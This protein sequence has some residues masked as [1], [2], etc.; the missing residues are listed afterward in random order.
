MALWIILVLGWLF[1]LLLALSLIRIAG[2]T[3]KKIR[4]RAQNHRPRDR[5]DQA[6]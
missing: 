1:V 3:E 5:D 4:S 6:A 2:Y